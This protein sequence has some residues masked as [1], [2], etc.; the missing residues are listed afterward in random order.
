M[1]RFTLAGLVAA[2]SVSALAAQP[3][4][5]A[6][7]ETYDVQF[8]YRIHADRDERIRQFRAMTDFLKTLDFKKDEKPDDDLDIFDPTA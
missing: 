7:P 8:R 5:P 3:I 6:A 1:L 2:I 4:R